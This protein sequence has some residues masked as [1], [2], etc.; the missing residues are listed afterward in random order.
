LLALR[1]KTREKPE[2]VFRKPPASTGGTN[3]T[4]SGVWPAT[5]PAVLM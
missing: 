1:A 5:M 4:I 2:A 3:N